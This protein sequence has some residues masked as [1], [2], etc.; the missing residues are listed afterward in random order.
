MAMKDKWM[1]N[2]Y[3]DNPLTPFVEPEADLNDPVRIEIMVN[4]GFSREEIVTSLRQG[5]FDDITATYYLLG[6][7]NSSLEPDSRIGS[8]LSLRLVFFMCISGY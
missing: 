2:G 4:M 7:R 1:N 8:N 5:A 3:E 6:R